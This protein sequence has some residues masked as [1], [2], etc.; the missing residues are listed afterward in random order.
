MSGISFIYPTDLGCVIS[1]YDDE[2]DVGRTWEMADDIAEK[3]YIMMI[4]WEGLE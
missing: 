2:N 4:E 3:G 1:Y